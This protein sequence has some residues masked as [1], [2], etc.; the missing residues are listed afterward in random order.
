LPMDELAARDAITVRALESTDGAREIWSDAD[1][2]WAGRAAAEALGESAPDD[3]FI[4]R[5]AALALE[6]LRK[7]HPGFVALTRSIP[8]RRSIVWATTAAAFVVGALGVDIGPAHRINLLAPPLLALFAWNIVV[9]VALLAS[10]IAS[11]RGKSSR[12]GGPLRHNVARLFRD[13]SMFRRKPAVPPA[14]LTAYGRFATEWSTLT[15]PLVAQRAAALL[16]LGA[17]ALAAGA[18]A[19]LYVRGIALEYRAGWQSTF[20]TA[21][22]VANI[23]HVV[24]A[25]GAWLTGIALPEA[26]HLQTIGGDS[27]GENAARWIH[28]YAAT[29]AAVVIVPRLALA[30]AAWLSQHTLA[31]SMPLSLRDPY[32][33]GLLRSWRRG[34]ARIAAIAYSYAIPAA[35]TQ[36][37]AQIATRALQSTVVIDWMPTIAYGADD[38]PPVDAASQTAVI[39]I[40]NLGATPERETHGAFV[41]TLADADPTLPLIAIVDTSEF[42]ARFADQPRRISER[43]DSW[44]RMLGA[45]DCEPL[46][47]ALAHPDVGRDG[48]ALALRLTDSTS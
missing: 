5:R 18:I 23:L 25:P 13:G 30:L 4:G 46:F 42:A 47:I 35:N 39:A 31:R 33:Q 37:L 44:R 27:P 32:F 19:G 40:F 15:A 48:A 45:I 14:L 20:L 1:R 34:T 16:H 29:I 8:L 22:N 7:R 36:G 21:E 10:A 24:L 12:W 6:R 38:V 9:Y 17:A 3:A 11:R 2:V 28:L 26:A 43:T 41:R